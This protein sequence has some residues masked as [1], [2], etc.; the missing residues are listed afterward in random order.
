MKQ[1]IHFNYDEEN[2]NEDKKEIDP[3]ENWEASEE[4]HCTTNQTQGRFG[5]HLGMAMIMWL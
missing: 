3:A 4:S 5:C 1:I 2:I